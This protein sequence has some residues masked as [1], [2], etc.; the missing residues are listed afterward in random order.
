MPA[1]TTG[2]L[3]AVEASMKIAEIRRRAFFS[4]ASRI[5]GIGVG[6]AF[7]ALFAGAATTFAAVAMT[8]R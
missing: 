6:L 2:R 7:T 8:S 1:I 5:A 4:P 3:K